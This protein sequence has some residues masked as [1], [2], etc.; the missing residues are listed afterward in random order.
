MLTPYAPRFVSFV[1]LIGQAGHS[2]HAS[3]QQGGRPAE[4]ARGWTFVK[5]DPDKTNKPATKQTNR[6][7]NQPNKQTN[8]QTII[9]DIYICICTHMSMDI[10]GGGGR[11]G[12]C[13]Y[14]G[15]L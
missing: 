11:R 8:K 7:T 5:K 6:P 3:G 15:K 12:A 2:G 1:S 13:C 4:D 10:V 9:F 14:W